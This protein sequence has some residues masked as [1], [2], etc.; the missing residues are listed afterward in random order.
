M[1]DLCFTYYKTPFEQYGVTHTAS[2]SEWVEAFSQHQLRGIPAD[3]S[4]KKALDKAKMGPALLLGEVSE[5][6][7]RA[8]AHVR[9]VNAL[10]LDLDSSPE[11]QVLAVLGALEPFE[12]YCWTTHKH[13]SEIAKGIPR[14]RII[15]PLAEPIEP[16]DH[17]SAWH[18]LNKLVGGANDPSTKD[19]ARL[20]FLPSTF[21]LS[22]A[23]TI[24]NPT[25]RWLAL[26]DLPDVELSAE[27]ST[28]FNQLQ[29][30][31]VAASIRAKIKRAEVGD[32]KPAL[33]ALAK[34]EPFADEGERH[35]RVLKLTYWIAEKS[36]HLSQGVIELLFA[37]S[38][39]KMGVGGPTM[40]EVWAAY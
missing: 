30:E 15:L 39:A 27:H 2:W 3:T 4:N 12:Y 21:D 10:S 36:E 8:K 18:G 23:E 9:R 24:H 35:T 38:L 33:N 37:S 5:G 7:P 17:A 34:G 29:N 28:V 25:N 26:E 1:R 11:A 13:G 19:I 31:K 20:N 22:V 6:D 16:A 14:L 40:N 32:D